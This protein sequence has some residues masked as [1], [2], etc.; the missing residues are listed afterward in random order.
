MKDQFSP[1]GI[2]FLRIS[3]PDF[4]NDDFAVLKYFNPIPLTAGETVDEIEDCIFNGFL[5]DE[6][7]VYVTLTGGCPG[8]YTFEV[9]NFFYILVYIEP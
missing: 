8:S 2:P 1:S 5:R 6:A 4:G 7:N 9:S 3:Y